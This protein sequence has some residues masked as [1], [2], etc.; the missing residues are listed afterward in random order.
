MVETIEMKIT[1]LIE[2]T[3]DDEKNLIIAD[4][5][6]LLDKAKMYRDSIERKFELILLLQS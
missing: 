5:Y 4:S 3:V 1:K 6:G 2:E